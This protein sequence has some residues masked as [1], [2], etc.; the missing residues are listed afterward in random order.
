MSKI[1]QFGRDKVLFLH[2]ETYSWRLLRELM[3]TLPKTVQAMLE[4]KDRHRKYWLWSSLEFYKL[5]LF[6]L[7]AVFLCMDIS[8][9]CWTHFLFF[10]QNMQK[11]GLAPYFVFLTNF[12]WS[13]HFILLRQEQSYK[14]LLRGSTGS[15]FGQSNDEL[16]PPP[17]SELMPVVTC[18]DGTELEEALREISREISSEFSCAKDTDTGTSPGWSLITNIYICQHTLN[19]SG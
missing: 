12:M 5:F 11:G 1:T 16:S 8:I 6:A 14:D 17:A 2:L 4:K 13:L 10:N 18:A 9:H 15:V 19:H 7:Y 3:R